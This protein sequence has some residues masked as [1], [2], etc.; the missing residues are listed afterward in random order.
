[1]PITAMQR[2]FYLCLIFLVSLAARKRTRQSA[3]GKPF[4]T[5]G[6]WVGLLRIASQKEALLSGQQ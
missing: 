6:G 2:S 5:L 1:M 3:S 4:Q